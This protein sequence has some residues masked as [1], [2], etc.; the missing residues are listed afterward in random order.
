VRKRKG[1]AI[2]SVTLERE[3]VIAVR[4]EPTRLERLLQNEKKAP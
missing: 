3:K 1:S 2:G 4:V